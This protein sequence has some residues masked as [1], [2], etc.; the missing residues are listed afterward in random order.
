MIIRI[1]MITPMLSDEFVHEIYID[2][3]DLN[4]NVDKASHVGVRVVIWT[5][6]SDAICEY[7]QC[8]L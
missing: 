7:R 4:N 1:I 5:S 3:N 6:P 8:N 2:D